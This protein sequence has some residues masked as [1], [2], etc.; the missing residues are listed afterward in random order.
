MAT[1][2]RPPHR[3]RHAY[4]KHTAKRKPPGKTH[5]FST[6]TL[7]HNYLAYDFADPPPNPPAT[8]P[9]PTHCQVSTRHQATQTPPP[10]PLSQPQVHQ[11][12]DMHST[13][14]GFVTCAA[15][16]AWSIYQPTITTAILAGPTQL[17]TLARWAWTVP[18]CPTICFACLYAAALWATFG[19]TTTAQFVRGC[20]TEA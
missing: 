16:A 3:R 10:Q 15:I 13:L 12:A 4:L 7:H 19:T 20:S 6:K 14:Q 17:A 11:S 18:A 5:T 8:A 9:I 2:R 1:S